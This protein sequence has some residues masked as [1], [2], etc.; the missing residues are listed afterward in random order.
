M[1][2]RVDVAGVDEGGEG[3]GDSV[4]QL[5]LV[6][7]AKLGLVVDLR[8]QEAP[9]S[10][11]YLAPIPKDVVEVAELQPRETPVSRSGDTFW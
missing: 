8:P 6:P 5:L 9:P 3:D 4:P 11:L 7:Q 10:R 1:S 2:A